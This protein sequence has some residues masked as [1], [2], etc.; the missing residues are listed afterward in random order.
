MTGN[1]LQQ[2]VETIRRSE[3]EELQLKRLRWQVKRCYENSAFY[4]E[5]FNE[6]NVTPDNVKK[7]EDIAKLPFLKKDELRSEQANHP[8]FGRYVIAP[9][10]SWRELHPSTGT[11]GMPVNTIWSAQDIKSIVEFTSRTMWSWGVR[12]GDIVQNGF[13]YGLWIAGI[14]VHY[15]ASRMGCFVIPMGATMTE[16]QIDYMGMVKSNIFVSTPSFA[17]YLAEILRKQ[18][19]KPENL[20]LEKGC[21]G[22]EPGTELPTTR[23]KIESGLGLD[24]HD[25]Y[26]LSEINPTMASECTEKSGLHWSEDHHLIE[27]IDQ[28]TLEPCSPGEQGVLVITH[29]T[30]EATPM[31]RYWTNDLAIL[32]LDKCGCGRTHGRSPRGIQGRADD[33]IIYKGAKFYPLQVEK[34]VRDIPELGEEFGIAIRRNKE[35]DTD[36]CSIQVEYV[37]GNINR[38]E[39]KKKL[40]DELKKEISVTPEIEFLEEGVLERTTFKAKRIVA[41]RDS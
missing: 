28:D 36:I 33:M 27:I 6:L 13:S 39:L 18:G 4:R 40:E 20:A 8:P 5:K 26:G 9:T 1:F 30:R 23:R 17:L 3:L 24:A 12:P 16:R 2:E 21:F 41:A 38:N 29:L 22:G 7:I 10:E 19:I 25:Y 37:S 34:V 15:A 32:E 31:I 14:A 35:R 11:T